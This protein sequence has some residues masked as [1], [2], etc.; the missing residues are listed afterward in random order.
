MNHAFPSQSPLR[1][2]SWRSGSFAQAAPSCGS[3]IRKSESFQAFPSRAS[4]T[5]CVRDTTYVRHLRSKDRQPLDHCLLVA[6]KVGWEKQR[7]RGHFAEQ[8]V[9]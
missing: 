2:W 6:V 3:P 8:D 4:R 5:P 9:A 7:Q 1:L